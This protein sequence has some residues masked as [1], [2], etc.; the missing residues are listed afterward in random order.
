MS[1]LIRSFRSSYVLNRY[2]HWEEAVMYRFNHVN[3]MRGLRRL[4]A[5]CSRLGDGVAWYVTAAVV[6]LFFGEPAWLP[7]GVMMLSAGLG[8]AIYAAIK[9]LT[10]RP[11]PHMAHED[12]VLSVA[13]L[14]KYSFPSGHTLHAVN[15]SIQIAVFAPSLAWLV[16]PFALLVALSRMVLGLHYLSDVLVGGLIGALLAVSSLWVVSAL[17]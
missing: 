4:F 14:D 10:A 8:L 2:L 1:A 15:F 7:M 3:A 6:A 12:L 17:S 5:I 13:P 16:I 9:H 11:R